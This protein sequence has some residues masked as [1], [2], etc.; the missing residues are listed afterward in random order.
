MAFDTD[1]RK[2]VRGQI[3]VAMRIHT[4]I[5]GPIITAPYT[6]NLH[7]VL[8]FFKL[9]MAVSRRPNSTVRTSD[10]CSN[11]MFRMFSSRPAAAR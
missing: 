8:E 6:E 9:I 1:E 2:F 3:A 11:Q 4:Y 10:T 5:V 7:F